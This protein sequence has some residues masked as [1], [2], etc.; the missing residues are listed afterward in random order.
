MGLLRTLFAKETRDLAFTGAGVLALLAGRRVTSLGL[1]ARG[2]YG[3]ER[4]WRKNHP[5]F[6]GSFGERWKLAEAFYEKTHQNE[7]NRWLHIVGIPIIV[8]GTVGLYAFRP[9]RPAWFASAG[10]FTFGWVLNFIGH[11]IFEKS[12]PAFKDDPLSFVAGPVWD[13]KQIR[14]R[15]TGAYTGGSTTANADDIPRKRG[16]DVS[17]N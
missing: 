3:L 9:F 16:V 14:N 4:T 12:A 10:A 1:V 17:V 15:F 5:E 8:G 2:L 6:E 7:T 11:G 13:L